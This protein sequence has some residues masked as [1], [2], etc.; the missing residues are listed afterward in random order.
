ML[1]QDTR[2]EQ[3]RSMEPLHKIYRFRIYDCPLE[4]EDC[5]LLILSEQSLEVI[6][7]LFCQVGPVVMEIKGDL[8]PVL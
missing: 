3:S 7:R 5:R 1:A 4:T 8:D 6:Q 2:T